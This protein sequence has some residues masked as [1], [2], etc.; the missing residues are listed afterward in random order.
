MPSDLR[1]EMGHGCPDALG[2]GLAG[3][4]QPALTGEQ[5]CVILITD[6]GMEGERT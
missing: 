4:A 1:Q 3:E 6:V 2:E 5:F